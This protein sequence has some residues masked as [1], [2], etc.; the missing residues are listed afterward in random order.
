MSQNDS[1]RAGDIVEVLSKEEILRTLDDKGQL[2][3]LPFM[4]QMFQYCGQR[5]RVYKRAHKTC[6]TVNR[7]AGRLMN[8]AVHLEGIRC[9]GQAY[10][11]CQA[12]CLIFWKNA[13]IKKVS[14]RGEA[15]NGNSPATA[16]EAV[17]EHVDEK[18]YNGTRV[19]GEGDNGEPTYVCQTT[20]L[21]AATKPLSPWD[22]RQY[23]EDYASGNAS[24]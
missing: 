2:Q 11:G 15:A 13:W 17:A 8:S 20:Q 7:P 21:P 19:G 3:N 9:D 14:D 10:G 1:F 5:F 6:D 18:V 16:I 12:G 24:L 4:P 23:L 22:V